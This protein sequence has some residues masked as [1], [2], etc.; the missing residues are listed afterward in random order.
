MCVSKTKT[1][2]YILAWINFGLTFWSNLLIHIN[3][4]KLDKNPKFGHVYKLNWP[5]MKTY[6]VIYCIEFKCQPEYFSII[7]AH[8]TANSC[9]INL[10]FLQFYSFQTL[11]AWKFQTMTCDL[12]WLVAFAANQNL[13]AT[14][15]FCYTTYRKVASIFPKV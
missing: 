7:D 11:F 1:N 4:T 14:P 15:T 10:F 2:R 13:F 12:F 6:W 8:S 5:W 3:I 9:K